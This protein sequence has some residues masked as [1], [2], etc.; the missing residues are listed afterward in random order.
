MNIKLTRRENLRILAKSVGGIT[1]LADRLNKTQSQISHLIGNKPIK[2]IGDKIA[3]QVEEAF[4]K[5]S[6]WLD[7]QHQSI[8]KKLPAYSIPQN[9]QTGILCR[10]IPLISWEDVTQWNQFAYSYKPKN[11]EYMVPTTANVGPLAFALRVYGDSMES[12]TGMSFP[13]NSIIIT[14]PDAVPTFGSFIVVRISKDRGATLKQ[15]IIQGHKRYLKPLNRRYPILEFTSNTIVLGVVKQMVIN[16]D[17]LPVK[18]KLSQMQIKQR[19][20]ELA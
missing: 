1:R 7:R 9:G 17:S 2:N 11:G 20:S 6:G 10:Q 15:L 12:S 16:F 3:T 8:E 18:P 19:T 5:P 14:D 13:E 4:N